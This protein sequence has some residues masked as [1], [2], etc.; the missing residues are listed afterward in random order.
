MSAIKKAVWSW[1]TDNSVNMFKELKVKDV[2]NSYF[3]ED[4]KLD[5]IQPRER[6]SWR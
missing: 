6:A 3:L 5:N 1:E 2:W 4:F